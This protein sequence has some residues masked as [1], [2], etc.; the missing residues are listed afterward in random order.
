MRWELCLPIGSVLA[1]GLAAA[2]WAYYKKHMEAGQPHGSPARWRSVLRPN[3]RS[4]ETQRACI[5]EKQPAR[6]NDRTVA[7]GCRTG[8]QSRRTLVDGD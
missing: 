6:L 1:G 2:Q 8:E 3:S 5:V 7:Q 4:D